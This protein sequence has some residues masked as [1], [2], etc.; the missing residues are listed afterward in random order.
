[1]R[2]LKLF[3]K[4]RGV[5]GISMVLSL[6]LVSNMLAPLPLMAYWVDQEYT[7]IVEEWVDDYEFNGTNWVWVGEHLETHEETYTIPVWVD[8]GGEDEEEGSD[9]STTEPI[10]TASGNNYF[11][12]NRL[13]VP[14]PGLPLELDLKYQSIANG[15]AGILGQGWRHS[16]E[17]TLDVQTNDA[18]LCTGAGNR[19]VFT[20]GT[21]GLYQPP[22]GSKWNLAAS[23]GGHELSLPGGK[24]YRFGSA[25]RLATIQDAWGNWVECSYGTNGCLEAATHSN[26]RQLVFSN[27][28]EAAAGEWRVASIGVLGGESLAFAYNADGQFTQVV[29]QVGA[30]SHTSSYQYADGYLTNKVNGAGFEYAFGYETGVGGHLNGK[31]THLAV[32]GYYEHDVAYTSTDMTDVTYHMRG[33]EQVYRYSR[34]ERGLL[35][36]RHGPGE[37]VGDAYQRGVRYAYDGDGMDKTEET[38]FDNGAGATWSRW[39]QYDDSHNMTNL[40]V[41]YGSTNPVPLLSLEYD[42]VW[43]LPLA[44]EDADDLRMEIAYVNGSP[45]IV[46]SFHS[47][48]NSYDTHL[49]YTTN[50][51]LRA[52]TNANGHVVAFGY[53]DMGNRV[54]IAPQA[55]P[56]ITNTYNALGFAT[57]AE[58]LSEN[59]VPTGRAT[60][61]VRD[62]KGRVVQAVFADGLTNSYAY[63]ALGYLMRAIDRAG[64]ATDYAYAPTRRHSSVTKYLE[65]GGSN[66]TV[67][68]GYDLDQQMNLLRIAEP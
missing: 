48:T 7:V 2:T 64:R 5:A 51:L 49:G 10:D 9:G 43:Q 47:A 55:G 4:K 65:Q 59:G 52:L 16:C 39:M 40:S 45:W 44:I 36:A 46:K 25:G 33:L 54:S 12:E 68:N 57:G 34:D 19:F 13:Y 27:Q 14:C 20:Q 8:E 31:G 18:T 26:G 62:A 63:N 21:N 37:T 23:G 1:M 24:T 60:Q 15:P 50:G 17:W 3:G 29:E 11:T 32:D 53:D 30:N 61:Y 28:W 66:V 56:S 67:R 58:M 41:A 6:A 35:A 22:R 42:S 38:L